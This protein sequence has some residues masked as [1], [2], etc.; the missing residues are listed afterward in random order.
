MLLYENDYFSLIEK[1]SELFINVIEP[2]YDIKKFSGL[3]YE[4]PRIKVKNFMNLR[5]ALKK[6]ENQD[7]KIGLYLPAVELY[8]SNDEM[9][10]RVKLNL[11]KDYINNNKKEVMTKILN[12]LKEKD[13][14]E[15]INYDVFQDIPSKEE[16]LIAEGVYPKPGRD[17]EVK[18][19]QLSQKKPVIKKDGSADHYD[20]NLIDEVKEGDWLGEKVLPTEGEAGKTVTGKKVPAKKGHDESLRYDSKSVGLVEEGGKQILKALINGAVKKQNGRIKVEDHMI[21]KKDVDFSTG[22]IKFDGHV[23][24]KGTV[25]TGF[26]VIATKD[27]SIDS[28]TGLGAVEKIVSKKGSVY[29]R[30]GINGKGK[31]LIKAAKDVFVKYCNETEINAGGII[32]I[33]YYSMD[34][35]LK[36]EKVIFNKYKGRVIGGNIEAETQIQ[37]GTIGNKYEKKTKVNVQGF[38]RVKLKEELSKVLKKYKQLLASAEKIKLSLQVYSFNYEMHQKENYQKE[39]R[40]KKKEYEELMDKIMKLDKERK[41]LQKVLKS[42]GEGEISIYKRAYPKTYLK[43]K[44]MQKKIDNLVKGTFYVVDNDLHFQ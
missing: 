13:I 22:N 2:G 12:K 20:L 40:K 14:E 9:E 25:K 35:K 6:A 31:S 18:Y 27:I 28:T 34:S 44:T 3:T 33:G 7:I 41:R 24:I 26:S 15:G 43:I 23:T 16:F 36:G 19:Y 5:N 38:N 37:T 39:N 4:F 10:C 11:I 1:N 30:G 29:I 17:A 32:N 21:I 8:I 42:K